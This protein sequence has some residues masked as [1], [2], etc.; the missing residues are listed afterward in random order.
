ML[1]SISKT[2][3]V[4]VT[5]IQATMAS[6]GAPSPQTLDINVQGGGKAGI[7]QSGM[8][9]AADTTA[10]R[11]FFVTGNARGPGANK[12]QNGLPASGKTY[13][14]TLEQCVVN[15]AVDPSQGTLTQAD[16]FE[17][18]AYDSLNGG[19][20][21]F[22]SAGVALLDPTVF[23]GNGVSRIAVAGGKDGNVY[24][25]NADDLGGFAGGN[26]GANN[27]I[28]TIPNGN[29]YFNGPG[30]YPLEGG[31][32]YLSP[33]G[34]SMYAYSFNRDGSG[35]PLF[36]LAGKTALTF[37]GK[38]VPTVTTNNG[39]PGTGIVWLTDVNKG[40]LAYNAV[41]V[42]GV[43]TPI[44]L[45]VG[46]ATGGLTKYQ[47]AV[48]GDGRIYTTKANTVM[49]LSGAGQKS[50]IPLSCT[51]NPLDFGSVMIDQTSAVQVTC[52]AKAAITNPKCDITSAIFQ[53]GSATLP[54]SVA[55]G[56]QFSFPVVSTLRK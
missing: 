2:P 30:S 55:S 27:V 7:W 32:I 29:S 3:G 8:G 18:Y 39:A 11:V 47:R 15:M 54:A 28:Q 53:C 48:F 34:D 16:Y 46:A 1:V 41:P 35:K 44:T 42:N 31:Y 43:L 45:P 24:I 37:A 40:L 36:T 49:S 10:N 4:G 25:M 17:P 51:P 19:D 22:G 50:K 6:P 9:L 26:A 33:S 56:S 21:D 23:H 38:S 52:T 5:N 13:L 14:S 20:R 12:G